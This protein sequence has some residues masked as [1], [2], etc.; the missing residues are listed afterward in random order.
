MAKTPAPA[1]SSLPE[2]EGMSL[3]ELTN[4]HHT[5]GKHLEERKAARIK[6]LQAELAA[7]GGNGVGIKRPTDGDKINN[8]RSR[9]K[10]PITHRGPGGETW[11]SRGA[12]PKWLAALIAEG[13]NPDDYRV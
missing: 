4:L 6:E 5:V 11:T 9:A 7:L 8:G 2:F 12:K 13:K 3:D 10:P 1:P